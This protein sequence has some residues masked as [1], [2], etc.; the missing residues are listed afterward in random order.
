M[1]LGL[2]ALFGGTFAKIA[3]AS[4][5]LFA[6]V[7]AVLRVLGAASERR[8]VLLDKF[9][10]TACPAMKA[11]AALAVEE[12]KEAAKKN[13]DMFQQAYARS[14]P[15]PPPLPPVAELSVEARLVNLQSLREKN[16]ITEEEYATRRTALLKCI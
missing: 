14:E 2:L 9:H 10:L 6:C 1:V 15:A 3:T 12:N 8:S 13:R 16:L 7:L 5:F 11:L 4:A